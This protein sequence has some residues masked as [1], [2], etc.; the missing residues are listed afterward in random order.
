MDKKNV[1]VIQEWPIPK[2]VIEVRGFHGLISF[3]RRFVKDFS[4][5][6]T[7]LFNVGDNLKLNPFKERWWCVC[8]FVS[9]CF[10]NSKLWKDSLLCVKIEVVR[11]EL[12]A[13][14]LFVCF[15]LQKATWHIFAQKFFLNKDFTQQFFLL[16]YYIRHIG[17]IFRII[18][19]HVLGFILFWINVS[20]LG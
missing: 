15:G 17:F 18:I 7:P 19:I 14:V 20:P 4:A 5:L 13:R 12:I 6:L 16:L 8:L 2:S 11:E 1:K 3:Y 9:M 10:M